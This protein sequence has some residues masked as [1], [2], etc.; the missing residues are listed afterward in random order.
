MY[1]LV[2]YKTKTA[3]KTSVGGFGSNNNGGDGN[4]ISNNDI[5]G[6][7]GVDGYS[8]SSSSAKVGCK[9]EVVSNASSIIMERLLNSSNSSNSNSSN[10]SSTSNSSSSS[11][12]GIM[13][14]IDSS[15]RL[16]TFDSNDPEFDDDYDP[17]ADLDI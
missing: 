8:G 16:I 13:H 6:S 1:P 12:G 2:D 11:V 10:S 5:S 9:E 15:K 3:I 7:D 4:G 14:G 17:D